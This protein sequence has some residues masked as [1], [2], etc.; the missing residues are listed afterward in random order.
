MPNGSDL[1]KDDKRWDPPQSS[2]HGAWG[3]SALAFFKEID[4]TSWKV[5]DESCAYGTHISKK[6]MTSTLVL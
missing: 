1:I 5:H 2:W 6:H 4:M 3:L